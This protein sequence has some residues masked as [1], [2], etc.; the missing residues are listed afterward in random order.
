MCRYL[1]SCIQNQFRTRTLRCHENL[2]IRSV[3]SWLR[4]NPRRFKPFV[5]NRVAEVMELIPPDRWQHVPGKTNPAD[6]ASRGLYPSELVRQN[7]WW[8]G[9]SWLHDSPSKWPVL[10]ELIEKPEPSEEKVSS[11]ELLEIGLVIIAGE[12]P[13]LGKIS[14]Y[15]RLKRVTAWM[16][17]FIHNCR[18]HSKDEPCTS[19]WSSGQ[20][21]TRCCGEPVDCVCPAIYLPE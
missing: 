18:A 6:C 14:G 11:E 13:L 3:N 1:N 2:T 4:G 5:G 7:S 15:G 12:L 8:N 17:R 16:C 10:L 19:H 9:P 21:R 20:F